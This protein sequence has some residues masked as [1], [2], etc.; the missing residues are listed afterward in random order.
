MPV[1]LERAFEELR[2]HT[3]TVVLP[4]A[5]DLRRRGDRRRRTQMATALVTAA[6]A[7]AVFTVSVGVPGL[8]GSGH[9][10]SPAEPST[11]PQ[12]TPVAPSPFPSPSPAPWP[13]EQPSPSPAYPEYYEER[14]DLPPGC[15]DGTVALVQ[16]RQFAGDPLPASIMLRPADWGRCYEMYAD[17]AGYEV[18]SPEYVRPAPA[19][20][21]RYRTYPADEHRVAGRVQEFYGGPEI[22]GS[23]R[24]TRYAAG[25]ASAFM[26]QVRQAVSDCPSFSAEGQKWHVRILDTGF[27]GDD[28]MIIFI[29]T[30][31]ETPDDSYPGVFQ[32]VVRVG[33]LVVIVFPGFDLGGDRAYTI[34]MAQKA[35]ARLR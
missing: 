4:T 26:D 35:V 6:A 22:S 21:Q 19:L 32:A 14:I 16:A 11:S 9:P 25:Q 28:S 23:E 34:E 33:D 30:Q 15:D 1:D 24:V 13:S 29:G 10:I 2:A 27:A 20:C 12:P 18:Y 31:P 5:A 17:H 3:R 8:L 7:V